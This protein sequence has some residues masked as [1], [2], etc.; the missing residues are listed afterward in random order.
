MKLR[1][2]ILMLVILPLVLMAVVTYVLGSRNITV[3][4]TESISNGM[5]ATAIATRDAISVGVIGDF[6]V[7]ENGELWKGESLNISQRTDLADDVKE[8]TGMEVTVFFGDTRYMTSVI[9]EAGN[10]VI[11]TK[12][13]DVVIEHV[14]NKGETYFAQ[15]VDVAGEA[16]FAFYVPLYNDNSTTPVGMVFTGMS[17]EDAEAEIN[18]ILYK[19]L[20]VML[21]TMLICIA[22]AWVI[23]NGLVKG[24]NA[25]ISVLEEVANGNLTVQVNEKYSKRRDEI[26]G[27]IKA[28]GKLKTELISL[29][30]QIADKSKM[31]FAESE[32]LSTK[33]ESTSEMVGQVEKAVGEIATGAGSQAEET[34]AATEHIVMMG[35]MV[36]DT[37]AEV[38]NLSENSNQIKEASDNATFILKELDD[39][40]R[41]VT[42]AIEIIY[43][44]TNTTNESALK[45][46][47]A[48]NLIT[49]IAE[50]TNLLSLNASIEAAR[51]GDQGRGF[52]VVAGQ[53][54]KL[55]EQSDESA[56][57][58]EQITN[59]LIHDSE[60]AVATMN[61]IQEIMKQQNEKVNQT[62]ET[63]GNVKVGID[64]SITSIRA[65][66][67]QT[68]KLD[69]A[70]VRVIDVVQNLSAIAEENAAATQETSASVTEVS[71]IV[72]NIS[73]SAGDLKQIADELKQSI[74]IFKL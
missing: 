48:T 69:S 59:S 15:N 66:A 56:K 6:R 40:N 42:E 2:K 11:G 72:D 12:A 36:E 10:R 21:V 8:A 61:E 9:D 35:N 7:D 37:N 55:A 46:R 67:E 53:I 4:M 32:A 20:G 29:I 62:D 71:A 23:A 52:A 18:G 49:S 74:D 58:I 65:I 22:V 39:I 50:E 16:F 5:E 33:A 14:L 63:F 1:A 57:Q 25:G 54:Q 73:Q 3:A 27:M 43:N 68:R 34:Q 31:V 44:Q 41:K 24:I 64:Q 26:G 47:E 51:A 45:I 28:V 13:S 30:G 70:R 38:G 19:L 60:E 17:Q